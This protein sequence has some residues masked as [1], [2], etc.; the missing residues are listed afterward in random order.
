MTF[1]QKLR[2]VIARDIFGQEEL[3]LLF[4]AMSEAALHSG[5]TRALAAQELIKLKRGLYLFSKE[6][7]RGSVSKLAIAGKLYDPSYVSF[8]LALSHYG[9]IPEAVF[10]TTSACWQRKSKSFSTALGEFTFEYIPCRPFFTGVVSEKGVL[11]ATPL[12]ALFDLIYLRRKSYYSLDELESDW[13][14]ELSQLQKEVAKYSCSELERLAQ[15][16]KKKNI[17]Q[18]YEILIRAFK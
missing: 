5:I 16:Y 1:G 12:R 18:F 15:G 17:N 13:R 14:V 8:E 3:K 11:I 9:L 4:P 7:Q 2:K 10:T 6:L